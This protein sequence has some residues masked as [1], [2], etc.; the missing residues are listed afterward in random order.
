MKKM[1]I[2]MVLIVFVGTSIPFRFAYCQE[3]F[4]VH[5]GRPVFKLKD[6]EISYQQF[7]ET[8]DPEIRDYLI[9]WYT[10]LIE[11]VE[12]N[13]ARG[14]ITALLGRMKEDKELFC[15]C[16]EYYEKAVDEVKY[17]GMIYEMLFMINYE[18]GKDYN[19]SIED[20]IKNTKGWKRN[21][22]KKVKK[23]DMR[24]E[25]EKIKIKKKIKV[26]KKVSTIVLGRSFIELKNKAR[27]GFQMERIY[28]DWLSNTVDVFPYDYVPVE[29]IKK[30]H[31]GSR[32]REI[33]ASDLEFEMMPLT[34]TI[35]VKANDGKWY[36]PDEKGK[37]RFEVLGDKLMYPTTK[38]FKNI[39]LITDTHGISSLVP[40]AVKYDVDLVIGCGDYTGKMQA[41]YYLASKGINVYFPGDRFINEILGHDSKGVLLGSAPVKGNIIGGQPVSIDVQELIIV[42]DIGKPYPAQYYD[43]PTRYFTSLNKLVELNLEFVKVDELSE[44]YKIVERAKEKKAK[45]IAVRVFDEKDY[46]AVSEW[47][48]EDKDHRAILFHTSLYPTQKIFYE[49]PEQ[50]SFGDPHPVFE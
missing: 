31:E 1:I 47:L 5:S 14:E 6:T 44:T 19:S 40:D 7:W 49:F 4:S 21:F 9:D 36:A 43:A 13:F 20:V 50:T 39:C 25:I 41:A 26:P 2:L 27:I 28:R 12:T 35:V 37:F 29:N 24:F 32:L 16:I 15:Q 8:F 42:Q 11:K 34:A 3:P 46:E 18:C 22:Y 48:K 17:P 33:L 30:Y 23:G 10:K 38:R 45:V